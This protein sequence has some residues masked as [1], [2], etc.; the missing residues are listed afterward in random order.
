MT[1]PV[2]VLDGEEIELAPTLESLDRLE[3]LLRAYDSADGLKTLWLKSARGD[4]RSIALAIASA[5]GKRD[6]DAVSRKV[7]HDGVVNFTGPVGDF[8]F[9]LMYGG[10][11]PEEVFS[12]EREVS[13]ESPNPRKKK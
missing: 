3:N 13:D 11:T 12:E 6:V 5:S 9:S 8:Y 7:W 4:R 10:K 2:V 1:N